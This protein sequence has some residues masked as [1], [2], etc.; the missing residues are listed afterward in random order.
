MT[1]RGNKD[2][3]LISDDSDIELVAFGLEDIIVVSTTDAVLVGNKQKKNEIRG[4]VETLV[5]DKKRQATNFRRVFRPWG[6]F[7]TLIKR[8]KFHVKSISV[9][10]GSRL[11]LQSHKYRSE[12]WVVVEGEAQVTLNNKVKTVRTNE[13]I[14]VQLGAVHRL[15]NK[16]TNPLIIIEVQVGSYLEEDDIIRLEDDYSRKHE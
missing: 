3:I 14:Y 1:Q 16:T 4:L 5:N 10:P 7:E 12:H 11:S 9:N 6:F 8:D 15:E 2:S 13:S